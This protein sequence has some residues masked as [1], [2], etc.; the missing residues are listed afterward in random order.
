[1]KPRPWQNEEWT[2]DPDM[3]GGHEPDD[4]RAIPVVECGSG[5]LEHHI[6]RSTDDARARLRLAAAAPDMA[7]L[8]VDIG[9]VDYGKP[10]PVCREDVRSPGA[11]TY[12]SDHADDCRLVAVLRK[13][14]VR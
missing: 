3:V 4:W 8:L 5:R 1:M 13:A 6:D 9:Q 10:C 11:G 7:R 14:G 12:D 2:Y